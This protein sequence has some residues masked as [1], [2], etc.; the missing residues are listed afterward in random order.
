MRGWLHVS[1]ICAVQW[2]MILAGSGL[3]AE[4]PWADRAR[5]IGL[6]GLCVLVL[7]P[8]GAR[9]R[10][11]SSVDLFAGVFLLLALV[12]VLETSYQQTA[13]LRTISALLLYVAVF[14][15]IW[16]FA[17]Q[18]GEEIILRSLGWCLGLCLL[19]GLLAA[20]TGLVNVWQIDGRF[21]GLTG[22]PN[23][24]GLLGAIAFPLLLIQAIERHRWIDFTLVLAA[25][26]SVMLSGSRTS[27][28]SCAIATAF[29]LARAGMGRGL[30]ILMMAGI[31]AVAL[32]I[33]RPWEKSED[34]TGTALFDN[35]LSRLSFKDDTLMGGG[36]F[37]VWPVAIDAI[38]ESLLIGHGFG[39]E[40]FWLDESDINMEQFKLHQGKYMH[41][42]YLGLTYQLGIVGSCVL[43]IPL[44]GLAL[45]A[46]IRLLRRQLTL[47]QTSYVAVLLTGL[48]AAGSES[49]IY[50]VGNAFCFPFWTVIM[51]L[52]RSLANKRWRIGASSSARSQPAVAT[53]GGQ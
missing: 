20:L 36:R 15:S 23:S 14:W 51:L 26:A 42:S 39:T 1:V 31:L 2:A 53:A 16:H 11:L 34:Y 43:F 49:W 12:S 32:L 7:P 21:R 37:E 40:E 50:S 10:T 3:L 46:T 24:I 13:L 44:I 25:A 17:D 8:S 35:P 28:L 9:A 41:N 22:N 52:I 45:K 18:A 6:V 27:A 30:I 19:G 38:K 47:Q 4:N 48:V 33:I 29:I 5:W